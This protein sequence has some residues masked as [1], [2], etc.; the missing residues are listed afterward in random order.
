MA[1]LTAIMNEMSTSGR[2][3]TK[4]LVDE[5]E[6]TTGKMATEQSVAILRYGP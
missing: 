5:P 2:G 4:A 1:N 6:S 3:S